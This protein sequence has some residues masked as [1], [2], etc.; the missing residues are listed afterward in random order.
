MAEKSPVI[1]FLFRTL[2]GEFLLLGRGDFFSRMRKIFPCLEKNI[3]PLAKKGKRNLGNGLLK[4][5]E[6]VTFI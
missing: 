1:V 2:V 6:K 5:E 3:C 4:M